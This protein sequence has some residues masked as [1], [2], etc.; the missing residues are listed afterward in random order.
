MSASDAEIIN[1]EG[2]VEA[3]RAYLDG[4]TDQDGLA[5]CIAEG[6]AIAQILEPLV[7]PNPIIAAVHA[8]PLF[9][10]ELLNIN[11]IENRDIKSISRFIL[12]LKQLDEF[13]LP[14]HWQ[15]GEA[16]AVQQSEALR[17]MLLAVVSD[18]RLVLVRIV[19][20]LLRLR[21]ARREP[22]A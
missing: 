2:I 6:C 13:S 17:K 5:P 22:R 18:V 16:L 11:S 9:R 21:E 3:V 7:M 1:D 20:Q 4:L 19:D 15:P 14:R 8:Y 12:G 10:D